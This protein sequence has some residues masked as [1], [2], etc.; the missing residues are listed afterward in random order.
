VSLPVARRKENWEL[1]FPGLARKVAPV[2]PGPWFQYRDPVGFEWNTFEVYLTDL[3]PA[4]DGFRLVQISDLH[5]RPG[6]Q[7]AYDDLI[8]RL[9]ADEPD[10]ILITGDIVDDADYPYKC[11]PTARRLLSQLRARQGVLGVRGNHDEN[12]DAGD[13]NSTPL[14]LVEGQRLL[15]PHRGAAIELIAIPGP[16]RSDYPAGFEDSFPPNAT[17][18]PRIVMSHYPDHFRKMRA[19]APDIFLCGHTHGGQ[20]CLPGTLPLLRHDSLPM[21]YFL[22]VHR[23]D[24][25]CFFVNRGFG[26]S[27]QQVRIFCPSEVIEVRL[28]R[29][30]VEDRG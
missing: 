21:R 5:C 16:L 15:L 19:T 25:T 3:P 12:V 23:L 13:F 4:L 10:L 24:K 22:G 20:I 17:G 18:V 26:F 28:R 30:G 2:T 1:V 14:R 8:D 6:W 29:M 27:T 9:S 11:L 7:T